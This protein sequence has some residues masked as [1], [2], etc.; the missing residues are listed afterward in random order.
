MPSLLAI[1][2][3]RWWPLDISLANWVRYPLMV[4][5]DHW[6]NVIYIDDDARC[7]LER[8]LCLHRSHGIGHCCRIFAHHQVKSVCSNVPTV[9]VC[10]CVWE[11]SIVDCRH[12]PTIR[13]DITATWRLCMHC[14]GQLSHL[15][16]NS[17]STA[18]CWLMSLLSNWHLIA[19]LS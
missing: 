2:H 8:P 10:A 4:L 1:V 19:E 6:L 5:S 11:I 17:A 12:S 13:R 18:I 9:F 15:S 3:L 16:G 7:L 14:F